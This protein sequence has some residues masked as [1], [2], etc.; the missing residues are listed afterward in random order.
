MHMILIV[1]DDAFFREVFSEL[2]REEGYLVDTASSGN[3]GLKM[4]E[5]SRY[6]LIVT[7][8]VLQ[9]ISGLDILSRAK[10]LDSDDQPLKSPAT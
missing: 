10:Q 7:D 8:M 5:S 1:E 2:L 4:L 3:Q 9:D 6:D